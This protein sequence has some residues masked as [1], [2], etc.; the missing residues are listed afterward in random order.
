MGWVS[1]TGCDVKAAHTTIST[2][3]IKNTIYDVC[4]PGN[5]R[6]ISDEEYSAAL[7]EA[8]F[9]ETKEG[10]PDSTSPST[11]YS[12]L[13]DMNEIPKGV[14]HLSDKEK[15]NQRAAFL[16]HLHSNPCDTESTAELKKRSGTDLKTSPLMVELVRAIGHGHHWTEEED[17]STTDYVYCFGLR[18]F[19][20]Y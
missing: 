17:F 14:V 6:E 12:S 2:A 7:N 19:G 18:V 1:R 16:S 10:S 8:F 3:Y 13:E 9:S 5:P 20:S 4:T 11:K 15:A